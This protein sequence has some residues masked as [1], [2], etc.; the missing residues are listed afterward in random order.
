MTTGGGSQL[1]D[2]IASRDDSAPDGAARVS[3]PPPRPPPRCRGRDRGTGRRN[4]YCIALA[5]RDAALEKLSPFHPESFALLKDFAVRHG[6][7]PAASAAAGLAATVLPE[8]PPADVRELARVKVIIGAPQE[9]VADQKKE[10]KTAI[11]EER[12]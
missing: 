9:A 8:A 7:C 2:S 10:L 5:K 12:A 6:A 1:D 3:P 11:E 4:R